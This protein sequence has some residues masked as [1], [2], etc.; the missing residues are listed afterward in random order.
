MGGAAPPHGAFSGGSSGGAAAHASGAAWGRPL[1]T[2]CPQ[3]GGAHGAQL[4]HAPMELASAAWRGGAD[5]RRRSLCGAGRTALRRA[6][7][8]ATASLLLL[9]ASCGKSLTSLD[10]MKL[11]DTDPQ[12]RRGAA[13]RGGTRAAAAVPAARGGAARRAPL[14]LWRFAAGTP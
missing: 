5:R 11:A 14:L 9:P 13:R 8:L 12:A 3:S 6:F 7:A 2:A 4:P 1:A 10:I